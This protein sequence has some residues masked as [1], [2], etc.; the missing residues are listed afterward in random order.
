MFEIGLWVIVLLAGILLARWARR[1][2]SPV[3]KSL[4]RF[5]AAGVIVSSV[6][7]L[8]YVG[9]LFHLSGY[10]PDFLTIDS[11]LDRGGAWDSATSQCMG[12]R[13]E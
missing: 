7:M 8:L 9:V 10:D 11:C 12:A 13:F 1:V 5:V 6:L 4:L 3:A 2:S